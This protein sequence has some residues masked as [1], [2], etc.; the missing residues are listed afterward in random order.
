MLDLST[1][2]PPQ[3]A[4]VLHGTGP[5]VV[6]AGA[7]SGKTR[8]IT[9]RIARLVSEQNVPA[10][11]ILAVTFTNKAAAEMRSRILALL[12]EGPSPWIGTFHSICARLL[13]RHAEALGMSPQFVIYDDTDQKSLTTRIVRELGLDDRRYA[14]RELMRYIERQKQQLLKPD[15]VETDSAHGEVAARVYALYE[16][17]IKAS[18]AVDFN[19]LLVH[20]VYALRSHEGIRN[21]LQNMW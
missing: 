5:L 12:P 18:N 1:L 13:R 11:R 16:Q 14:P 19:D 4:A 21:T 17:R 9:Y 2:N 20:M 10:Y 15:E 3:H 8:V 7:G 6:F